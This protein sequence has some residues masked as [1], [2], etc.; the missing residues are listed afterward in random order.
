MKIIEAEAMGMC[1]GVRDALQAMRSVEQPTQITVMGEL[2]HNPIVQR[3]LALRGFPQMGEK[4]RGAGA[5]RTRRVMITAHG[6]SNRERTRLLERGLEVM[7]TT[8]PL[9]RKA[10]GAALGLARSGYFVV[11]I[12][13][14]GHV[15][16]RGLTGDLPEGGFDV[17]ENVHGVRVF[18]ADKIGVMAQ[19]TTAEREARE[20]VQRIRELNVKAEVRFVNTICQPTRDRQTALERLLEQ[21]NVLVVVGGRHSNNTR[22]LVS[23][24]R[25]AGVRCVHVEGADEL[26]P[27]MF[28]PHEVAGLTAGT[29]T[30]P[31]TVA[32]V[33]EK[34]ARFYADPF[35]TR[36][37]P[38]MEAAPHIRA[39]G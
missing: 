15:E 9:V 26:A 34:L 38:Q 19:T 33:K 35:R 39:A 21:V 22:Q 16:V 18:G 11:V 4:D 10:H 25:E 37:V 20:I 6:I 7:D 5:V 2:V 12:G 27:G 31:E 36:G 14:R 17:V 23:R 30:L 8:C 28:S 32:A 3:E 29:S 1:F 13:K 24:A